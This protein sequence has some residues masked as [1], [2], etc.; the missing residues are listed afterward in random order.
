MLVLG[1]PTFTTNNKILEETGMMSV[2]S[3]ISVSAQTIIMELFQSRY[4]PVGDSDISLFVF[5]AGYGKGGVS[6]R[7]THLATKNVEYCIIGSDF[8][9]KEYVLLIH[10]S[11]IQSQ[12][13]F[14]IK[15]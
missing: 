4:Y 5:A 14:F 8:L 10:E 2:V 11:C 1:Q 12:A 9:L 15:Y 7:T 3:D 13:L 6:T